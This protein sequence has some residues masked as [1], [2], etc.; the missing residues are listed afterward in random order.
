MPHAT[1]DAEVDQTAAINWVFL[2]EVTL[3]E[4]RRPHHGS[5]EFFIIES[6][7][8]GLRKFRKHH[9]CRERG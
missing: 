9:R 3:D 2:T 1:I 4:L 6:L 5:F 7:T 8:S